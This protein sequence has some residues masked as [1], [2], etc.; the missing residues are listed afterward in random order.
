[1]EKIEVRRER[2]ED[3]REYWF[4]KAFGMEFE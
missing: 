3:R 2:L 1:M 4:P